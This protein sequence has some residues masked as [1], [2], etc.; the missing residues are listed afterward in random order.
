MNACIKTKSGVVVGFVCFFFPLSIG[1]TGTRAGTPRV[2]R[3]DGLGLWGRLTGREQLM[4]RHFP[5][6]VSK[7]VRCNA[8]WPRFRPQTQVHFNLLSSSSVV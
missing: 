8:S 7:I 3:V 2:L 1:L 4:C 6:D 5:S